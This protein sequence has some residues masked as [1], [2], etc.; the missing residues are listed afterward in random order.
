MNKESL[1]S[2]IIRDIEAQDTYEFEEHIHSYLS[3]Y[4]MDDFY[5]LAMSD[6]LLDQGRYVD[7]IDLLEGALKYNSV[8]PF[9][10]ER[11]ADAYFYLEDY[12]KAY[13]YLSVIRLTEDN[14]D[15]LRI[16]FLLGMCCLKLKDFKRA[17]NYFEDYLLD[18]ES[19]KAY[20][21]CAE[22]YFELHQFDDAYDYFRKSM[23]LN[24][25]SSIIQVGRS[26]AK[27]NDFNYITKFIHFY[28]LQVYEDYFY[29]IHFYEM[30]QYGI[31]AKYLEQYISNGNDDNY[32]LKGLGDCFSKM[33]QYD[34]ATQ[35]YKSIIDD[36]FEILEDLDSFEM[37]LLL[38]CIND[39]HGENMYKEACFKRI[40]NTIELD[41]ELYYDVFQCCLDNEL[42][43]LCDY[44]R[45][46]YDFDE[47][48]IEM[49]YL[50][51][52]LLI[53]KE[54]FNEA[55]SLMESVD[56]HYKNDKYDKYY[57]LI[58]FYMDD[59]QYVI[60]HGVDLLPDGR[61]AIMLIA[62]YKE[63]NMISQELGLLEKMRA[64]LSTDFVDKEIYIEFLKNY[65]GD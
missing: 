15:Y 26:I 8:N 29:Y 2:K 43:N 57:I 41:D 60:D 50:H 20:F 55:L 31:A 13:S 65:L 17:C 44:L 39:I 53:L 24:D 54:E 38:D 25:V 52:N 48:N 45:V 16:V 58:K 23:D 30:E 56:S 46:Q 36:Y 33:K 64:Y 32:L 34:K 28:D 1:Q 5:Y 27:F 6:Y 11:I 10:Y 9:Y 42:I 22:C 21:Y 18:E 61:I 40:I 63:L 59:Y 37:Y 47:Q 49:F 14:P 51:L 35:I 4:G 62:S 7:I 19:R 3:Y 12:S